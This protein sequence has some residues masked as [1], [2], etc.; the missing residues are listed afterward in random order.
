[1]LK[2]DRLEEALPVARE[3]CA[4]AEAAGDIEQLWRALDD[5]ARIHSALGDIDVG[6]AYFERA[7]SA[8]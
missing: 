8:A 2:L 7:L 6:R 1:M 3:A 4:A 5:V